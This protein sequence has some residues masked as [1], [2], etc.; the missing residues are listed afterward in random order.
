MQ[1][2]HQTQGYNDNKNEEATMRYD[3]NSNSVYPVNVTGVQSLDQHINSGILNQKYQA[4][5]TAYP[6]DNNNIVAYPV[7]Q[8]EVKNHGGEGGG[9]P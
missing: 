1:E 4:H 8:E 6:S 3:R 7:A 5:K 2:G 9:E